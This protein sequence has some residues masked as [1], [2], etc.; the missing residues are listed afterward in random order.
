MTPLIAALVRRFL[1]GLLLVYAVTLAGCTAWVGTTAKSFMSHV[2]N[3]PDPNV[4]YI[5]YTKLADPQAYDSPEEKDE[6]VRILD[7]KIRERSRA[8]RHQGHDLPDA[9]TA[10]RSPCAR[11]AHQRSKQFG[12]RDQD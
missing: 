9:G 1:S 11:S 4:R 3:D 5:A 6:A 12:G 7:R 10:W 8:D 2:R